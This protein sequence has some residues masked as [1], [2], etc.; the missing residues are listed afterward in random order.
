MPPQPN[1][2]SRPNRTTQHAIPVVTA[3][4]DIPVVTAG[5][6]T[7][8]ASAASNPE[9]LTR[10]LVVHAHFARRL[11]QLIDEYI[12]FRRLPPELLDDIQEIEQLLWE[13]EHNAQ[14]QS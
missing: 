9:N 12:V 1:V 6:D 11:T 14:F 5:Q 10:Q 13:R 2:T 8:H 4:Q 3:G 7:P